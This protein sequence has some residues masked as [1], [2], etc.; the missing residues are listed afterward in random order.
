MLIF[1]LKRKRG[2]EVWFAGASQ[3][4]SLYSGLIVSKRFYRS[5]REDTVIGG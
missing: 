2:N 1:S 4:R 3:F 5:V